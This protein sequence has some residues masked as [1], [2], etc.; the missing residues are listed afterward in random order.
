MMQTPRHGSMIQPNLGLPPRYL[1]PF[2]TEGGRGRLAIAK[3]FALLLPFIQFLLNTYA[4]LP[5]KVRHFLA[6]KAWALWVALHRALPENIARRGLSKTLSIEAHAMSNVLWGA[7]LFPM[8]LGMMRFALG[9]LDANYPPSKDMKV[10]VINEPEQGVKGVYLHT[11]PKCDKPNVL[12]WFYGGAFLAGDVKGNMG[13]AERYARKVGCDTFLVDLRRCP[14]FKADDIIQDGCRA[15]EWLLKRVEAS[16]IQLLGISSGG[17][18]AM[19]VMQLARAKAEDRK[20]YFLSDGPLPVPAAAVLLSPFVNYS[21]IMPSMRDNQK[22]DL[23]VNQSVCEYSWPMANDM[24][25]GEENRRAQSPLWNSMEGLPPLF[26]STSRH[27][28][29]WDEDAELAKLAKEAG[30]EVQLQDIPYQ[31]HVFQVLAAFLPEAQEA[32]KEIQAWMR[33]QPGW[34]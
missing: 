14:E 5:V 6:T 3:I 1:E 15:Y 30:V 8:S 33:A 12:M 4:K 34:A 32:E 21:E 17:G 20:K 19:R 2:L 11:G 18:V 22:L 23:I 26:V 7:R 28:A 16:R 13:L 29:C 25:G 31:C 27:E 9:E 24:C 10:E